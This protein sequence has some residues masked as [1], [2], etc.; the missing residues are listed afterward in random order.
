MTQWFDLGLELTIDGNRFHGNPAKFGIARP[1]MRY[2]EGTLSSLGRFHFTEW[3]HLNIKG[4]WGF[5]RN[6]E[7]YEGKDKQQSF[8]MKKTGYLS[9]QFIIGF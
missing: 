2:S 8:D 9:T 6:F 3:L 5:Y 4:G 7:F 1:F